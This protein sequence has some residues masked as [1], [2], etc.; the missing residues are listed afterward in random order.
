MV[1]TD[2]ADAQF[3]LRELATLFNIQTTLDSLVAITTDSRNIKPGKIFLPLVGERFDGHDFINEALNKG[4]C[5]SFCEKE[6]TN[7]VNGRYLD[8]KVIIVENTL[9][10]YHKLANYYLNKINP[11]VVAVTGSSGKTTVKDLIANILAEKYLVHKT[12]ANF[13]NEIG[14]PKTILEM[15]IGTQVIVLEF[16]MRKEGEIRYL[17]R[18]THPDIG[19]I[20]NIGT[21]HIGRLG[22]RE[23]ILKAKCELFEYL[24][25]EGVAIVFDNDELVNYLKGVWKGRIK[26]FGFEQAEN[27][28]YNHSGS[29]FRYK[30]SDY[31]IGASGRFHILNSLCAISVAEELG[32]SN[33]E[34]RNGLA[35]FEVPSGRGNVLKLGEEMYILDESYN[36]NPDSVKAAVTNLHDS[37]DKS[38]LKILVLGELAELG[39][40]GDK[41][42]SDLNKWFL[43]FDNLIIVTVGDKLKHIT[44][45]QNVENAE[46]CCNLLKKMIKPGSVILIKG[47]HVAGLDE[48]VKYFQMGV[49][50]KLL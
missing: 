14:V 46:D 50:S 2:K 9:D 39:E 32:L 16:A 1:L 7:K 22:S 6:K 33:G 45:A 43:Q 25:Q 15:A 26:V 37:F 38:Y 10:A 8:A 21:A 35:T 41:L 49:K 24:K 29:C 5:Y 31:M 19:V 44:K 40:H 18:T 30:G 34:M 13:N 20:T 36:A 27:I 23:A 48:V 12:E 42:L 3:Q 28:T 4:A 17:S 47:S 11:K